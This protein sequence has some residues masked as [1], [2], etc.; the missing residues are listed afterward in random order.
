D[1][2]GRAA[3]EPAAGSGSDGARR[4]G[5]Y[6]YSLITEATFVRSAAT[7]ADLPRDGLAE[8]AFVGRSNVG[9]SSLINAL[10]GR[11][12]ARTSAAPGK[13]R[14]VNIYR[15]ARGGGRPLYLVDLPGFGYAR[16]GGRE[17]EPLMA[18]YFT[19]RTVGALLLVDARHPGLTSDI[20]AWR[21][22][23]PE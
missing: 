17:F 11:T 7:A 13:A 6:D 22:L 14:L 2:V 12:I 1:C 20:E 16:G 10:A 21:W 9:K 3:G 23:Q 18:A 15:V 5:R 4:G 8:I 19:G